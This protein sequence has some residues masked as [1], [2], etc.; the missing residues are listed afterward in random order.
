[1]T[2]IEP[3]VNAVIVILFVAVVAIVLTGCYTE[4]GD[5]PLADRS[6]SHTEPIV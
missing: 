6:M 3:V 5:C 4:D 2:I 1:M